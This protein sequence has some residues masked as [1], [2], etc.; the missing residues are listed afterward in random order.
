[1]GVSLSFLLQT[2][3]R[4][5]NCKTHTCTSLI[6]LLETASITFFWCRDTNTI[7]LSLLKIWHRHD[8]HHHPCWMILL[9]Y[10]S[11]FI[12]DDLQMVG[13]CYQRNPLSDSSPFPM[14]FL[15][16]MYFPRENSLYIPQTQIDSSLLFIIYLQA[17]FYTGNLLLSRQDICRSRTRITMVV[18]L[19][20]FWMTMIHHQNVYIES[21]FKFDLPRIYLYVI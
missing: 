3:R 14:E 4:N 16:A 1:M 18:R 20:D 21:F 19:V 11:H 7:V 17:N 6:R 9:I 13:A 10:N 5:L 12:S 15:S 2:S 8:Y